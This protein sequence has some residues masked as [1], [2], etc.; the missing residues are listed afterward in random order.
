MSQDF[1]KRDTSSTFAKGMAVLRAFDDS[2]TRLTLAEVARI[3]DLDRATVRRLVLTLV[4]LGYVYRSEKHFSLSPK[5]LTLAGSFL[6][7]HR[8]GT[9]V[10]PLLNR[11][12]ERVRSPVSLAIVDAQHA[13]FVAQ[14]TLPDSG[15]T[16]GFT[17]GSKLPLLHTAIGRALLSAGDSVWSGEAIATIPFQ[18]YTPATVT[19]RRAIKRSVAECRDAG[20]AIVSNEFEPDVTGLAVPVNT[21]GGMVAAVGTSRPGTDVRSISAQ[22]KI[23]APL[24]QLATELVRSGIFSHGS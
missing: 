15:I 14:S 7:G 11:Y 8:F 18:R 13:V 16:F 21:P 19:N 6:R 12:A 2:H 4:D 1:S 24:K 23:V 3:T 10:Q 17:V 9:V 22:N 5:V 20:H